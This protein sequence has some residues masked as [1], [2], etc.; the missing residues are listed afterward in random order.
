VATF[1]ESGRGDVGRLQG[2]QP[3]EWRLRVGDI[4]FRFRNLD[5]GNTVC[6]LRVLPRSRAYRS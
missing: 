6:I 5:D 2:V 4:R 1:V 3:A